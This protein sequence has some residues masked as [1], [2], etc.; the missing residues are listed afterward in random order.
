MVLQILFA[1]GSDGR[2]DSLAAAGTLPPVSS[3]PRVSACVS[4][5]ACMQINACVW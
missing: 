3:K 5:H 1:S 2:L 4:A